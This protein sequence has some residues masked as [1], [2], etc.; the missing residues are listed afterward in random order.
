MISSR[1]ERAGTGVADGEGLGVLDGR[2]EGE[3]LKEGD[4]V[5][6]GVGVG[7]KI[8]SPFVGPPTPISVLLP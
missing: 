7:T 6:V 5:A 3:G 1:A 2:T 4:G 8:S